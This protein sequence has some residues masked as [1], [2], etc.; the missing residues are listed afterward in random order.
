[1]TFCIAIT[2]EPGAGKST[3]AMKLVEELKRRG[4]KVCGVTCPDV[5]VRGRRIG[6]KMVDIRSGKEEWLAK[7]EGCN[8][9]RVGRYRVCPQVVE[10]VKEAFS[11]DCDF[12]VIDE[13]G[14][15]ELKLDEV[16]KEF[17][18]VLRSGRP[19][20]VVHHLRLRDREFLEMLRNCKKIIVR[21]EAREEAY[22]EALEYLKEL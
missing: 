11:G 19:F 1:M 18:K 21:R 4:Y 7:V 14:P 12:Y 5:R 13:I 3:L 8:G 15:M 10:L 9:P 22:E 20:I 2:G 17:L 16:R 6:F